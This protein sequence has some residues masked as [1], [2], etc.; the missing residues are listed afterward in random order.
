MLLIDSATVLKSPAADLQ[1][2]A[3]IVAALFE[4]RRRGG[5]LSAQ[6]VPMRPAGRGSAFYSLPAYI[7]SAGMAGIKWTTHC[8][9]AE[10]YT[11][12]VVV[13]NDIDDGTPL[14]LLD[15]WVISAVRTA[16]VSLCFYKHLEGL[17][18][19][20][21]LL[22]G[23]GYQAEWQAAALFTRFPD[24]DLLRLWSRS[25]AHA[26][27]CRRRVEAILRCR[28][29]IEVVED[30]HAAARK[31]DFVVGACSADEPYL[32]KEDL[33]GC[34]YVHIGMNDVSGEAL[35]SYPRII[36]DEFETAK[37]RSAQSLFRLWR[38]D[39]SVESR[40]ELL[41]NLTGRIA[42]GDRFC[43]DS[44]GLSIFDLGLAAEAYRYAR[45]HGLGLDWPLFGR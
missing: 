3:R 8:R 29:P 2:A 20:A 28:L 7:E 23:A 13:L 43:F 10:P 12:P 32:T 24:L 42:L 9:G 40:V 17:E 39:P 30:L 26:E 31:S 14:A 33:A 34:G 38:S 22:C 1:H 15:G 19:N 5:A 11:K 16:A 45:E 44:F 4:E 41:E 21:V 25:A 36:C 6:E 27:D 35:L 37:R 18:K